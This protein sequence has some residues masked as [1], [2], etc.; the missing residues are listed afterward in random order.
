[1]AAGLDATLGELREIARGIHPA[2]LADGGLPSALNALARRCPVPVTLRVQVA[3][4]LPHS[5]E[6]AAY[7][8]VS[9]ALTN[10]AKHAGATTATVEAAAGEG[11]LRVCV[12][13]D[14][15]GG[16]NF[17]QGSGLVGLKDRVEA[18]GGR[19]ALHS[20]PGGGTTL[21]IHIPLRQDSLLA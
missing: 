2:V 18:L 5:V 6:V 9:E 15:R 3:T 4:R 20:P 13:D 17:G 10:T 12:R 19:I 21:E 11:T 14:G 16:A 7:Y 1:V 8:V